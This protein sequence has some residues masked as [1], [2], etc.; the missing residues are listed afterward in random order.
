MV[1]EQHLAL[2]RDHAVQ[3]LC[4]CLHM[5]MAHRGWKSV[6][7]SMELDLQAVVNDRLGAGNQT[8]VLVSLAWG[9]G[10]QDPPQPGNSASLKESSLKEG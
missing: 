4:V 7:D 9:S 10:F 1:A 8:L 5:S 3:H 2:Q 6:L